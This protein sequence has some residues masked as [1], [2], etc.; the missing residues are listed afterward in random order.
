MS[1]TPRT[2]VGHNSPEQVGPPVQVPSW[3]VESQARKVPCEQHARDPLCFE[4]Q[5]LP[6]AHFHILHQAQLL[7]PEKKSSRPGEGF[8]VTKSGDARVALVGFPSVGKSSLL[9][10]MTH[11]E[12]VVAAYEYVGL[13]VYPSPQPA[14]RPTLTRSYVHRQRSRPSRACSR[15]KARGSRCSTCPGSSR[16]LRLGAGAGGK[17][18]PWQRRPT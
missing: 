16:A 14:P 4:V 13:P 2:T 5:Q 6:D 7:E 8:D 18:W 1:T 10:K 11:T 3:F 17:S 12:S 9:S 15:S